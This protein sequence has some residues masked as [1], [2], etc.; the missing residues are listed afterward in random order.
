M[1]S[2]LFTAKVLEL[3]KSQT[4]RFA[5]GNPHEPFSGVWRLVA[6]NDDVYLGASKWSMRLFKISLHKSGVWILAGIEGSGV[7]FEHGNRRAKQWHR[8]LE[9]AN[10]VTRGLSIIVP[11]TSLGSR[12]LSTM[13]GKKKVVWYAAPAVGEMVYFTIYFV[14]PSI[15]TGWAPG[16]T[17]LAEL[18]LASGS[19]VLLLASTHPSPADFMATV[20]K[21]I[22]EAVVQM[23]DPSK[24][25]AG[26]HLWI[27]QSRDDLATPMIVDMPVSVGS[28]LVSE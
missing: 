10:G 9:H 17:V 28:E 25:T 22:R 3:A 16:E 1:Q 24:F 27:T 4:I 5:S 19:R 6:D 13:D 21:M 20:E 11:H 12:Q 18:S 2:K 26:S 7:T 15:V 23:K 8:P 14:E